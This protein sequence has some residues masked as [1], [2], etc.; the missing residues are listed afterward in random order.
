MGLLHSSSDKNHILHL[1]FWKYFSP[2]RCFQLL[3]LRLGLCS[4]VPSN[5][6]CW[7][8]VNLCGEE[9]LMLLGCWNFSP[10]ESSISEAMTS[11]ITPGIGV[12]MSSKRGGGIGIPMG[13]LYCSM[14]IELVPCKEGNSSKFSKWT[15]YGINVHS[16]GWTTGGLAFQV[17]APRQPYVPHTWLWEQILSTIWH[18]HWTF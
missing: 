14:F 7:K 12:T 11:S 1:L 10:Q 5:A 9:N 17:T 6:A 18:C 3:P 8:D 16:W 15:L 4:L 2:G 13:G